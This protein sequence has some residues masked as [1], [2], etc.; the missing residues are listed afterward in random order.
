MIGPSCLNTQENVSHDKATLK[1]TWKAVK[2]YNDFL[3]YMLDLSTVGIGICS[4]TATQQQKCDFRCK[5]KSYILQG[6]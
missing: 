3:Y 6:F 4:S 2:I 1:C 5:M